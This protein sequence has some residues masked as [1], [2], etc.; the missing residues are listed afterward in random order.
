M[1]LFP[2]V[3]QATSRAYRQQK[4]AE[5]EF[6]ATFLWRREAYPSQPFRLAIDCRPP[7]VSAVYQRRFRRH[8]RREKATW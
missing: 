6:L 8:N 3:D 1:I 4:E 2:D 7:L 5:D